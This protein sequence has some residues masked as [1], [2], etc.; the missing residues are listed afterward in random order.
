MCGRGSAVPSLLQPRWNKSV[1]VLVTFAL[2]SEFAPWR[3][4]HGFVRL[5]NTEFTAFDSNFGDSDV[6][7][8]VTGMGAERAQGVARKLLDWRPGLCIAAGFAGGLNAAHRAGDV[9][10]AANVRDGETQRTLA[11]DSRIVNRAEDAGARKIEMLW[12]SAYV[13]SAVGDKRRLGK[14]ADAVDM[15]SFFILNEARE[16][17]IPG[18]AIRAVSDAADERLPL[19][20]T[21]VLDDRGRVRPARMASAIAR[22]P[23]RIPGL[24][25]LGAASRRGARKLAKVLDATIETLD[26]ARE[27]NSQRAAAT[28]TA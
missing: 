13:I 10:V 1:K 3:R 2:E 21:R 23:Q 26:G 25:R 19:D 5:A 22:S 16:R 8:V 14:I 7:V 11:S 27:S 9:V 17:G 6:R 4:M 12:T 18:V 28:V 15:E 24:I 20:F